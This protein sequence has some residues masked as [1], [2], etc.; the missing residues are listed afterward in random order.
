[1]KKDILQKVV[2]AC[3]SSPMS[4]KYL[5]DNFQIYQQELNDIVKYLE[6]RGCEWLHKDTTLQLKYPMEWLDVDMLRSNV[7]STLHYFSEVESTN[8]FLL[9]HREL[10]KQGDICIAEYQNKPRAQRNKGWTAPYGSQL[11]FSMYW[12]FEPKH[13][14]SG[15]SL[16][17]GL[18]LLETLRSFDID[19]LA[20]KWPNDI[21][22]DGEKLAGILTECSTGASGKID[23]VIGIGINLYEFSSKT[24]I[25]QPVATLSD[26]MKQRINKTILAQA[27]WVNLSSYL[28][29]FEKYG[30]AYF[31]NKWLESD[32]FMNKP[33]EVIK[34][35]IRIFALHKGVDPS[36]Y[37]LLE[38]DGA[39][40]RHA[41]SNVSLRLAVD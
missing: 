15:L 6:E 33:V 39:V 30:F 14:I 29:N 5:C 25:N 10:L 22:R 3:I 38:I 40:V 19:D 20:A 18:A 16:T 31:Q 8:S 41:S 23:V 7:T 13:V 34:D 1:M 36:G 9:D 24:D 37:L 26:L 27:L 2:L 4:Y 12:S 21:Y 35:D 11:A 28:K 17:V 32:I